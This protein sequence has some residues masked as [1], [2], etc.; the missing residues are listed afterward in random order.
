MRT[1]NFLAIPA[2]AACLM[3]AGCGSPTNNPVLDGGNK[4]FTMSNTNPDLTVTAAKTGCNGYV[5]CQVDCLASATTQAEYDAC[6]VPCDK[7]VTAAGKSKFSAAIVCAQ[8]FCLGTNDMG[9]GECI[10]TAGSL[11][12]KNGTPANNGTPCGDCLNNTL[13]A[14]FQDVCKPTTSPDCN[15]AMC[16]GTTTACTASTP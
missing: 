16:A 15:P 2:L 6:I 8:N 10:V 7:N 1:F 3:V 11:T 5:Q 9:S 4:D 13:A 14:L 12:N